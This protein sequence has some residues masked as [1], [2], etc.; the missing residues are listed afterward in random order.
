MRRHEFV[1][2]KLVAAAMADT[3]QYLADR[4]RMR[5]A[6]K[7]AEDIGEL[8]HREAAWT[9]VCTAADPASAP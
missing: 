4:A 3:S 2:K 6:A 9:S 1:A 7:L 5:D 8:E